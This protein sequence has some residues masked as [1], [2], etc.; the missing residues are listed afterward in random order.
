MDLERKNDL[1]ETEETVDPSSNR[2]EMMK[3]VGA[4]ALGGLAFA[5]ATRAT[6]ADDDDDGG[7][8]GGGGRRR[9][10]GKRRR[11]GGGDND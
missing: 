9:R 4:L 3:R 7:G 11:G 5:A 10:G 8:G 1:A 2:R 6:G